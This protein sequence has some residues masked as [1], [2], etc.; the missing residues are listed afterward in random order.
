MLLSLPLRPTT[1]PDIANWTEKSA[2]SK[3]DIV[4]FLRNT[5]LE[6]TREIVDDH[7]KSGK[8]LRDALNRMFSISMDQKVFNL[9]K[10]LINTA[11]DENKSLDAPV[12]NFI[13]II[14]ELPAFDK[15]V[16]DEE[17]LLKLIR[18]LPF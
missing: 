13:G 10:R 12:S 1:D 11:F 3:S 17:N 16:T 15:T 14:D 4:L 6:M 5:V 8:E 18:S 2:K 7:S 9:H